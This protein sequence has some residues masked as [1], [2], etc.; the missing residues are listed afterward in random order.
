MNEWMNEWTGHKHK[1]Q[2]RLEVS[3][4]SAF[5]AL[6]TQA[7]WEESSKRDLGSDQGWFAKTTA[8]W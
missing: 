8:K 5:M 4:T 7:M 2:V 1:G 6:V 3:W